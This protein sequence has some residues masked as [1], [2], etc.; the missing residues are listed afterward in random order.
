M[1][2]FKLELQLTLVALL[3]LLN[4]DSKILVLLPVDL[5]TLG[6]IV[7]KVATIAALVLVVVGL[8]DSLVGEVLVLS[9]LEDEAESG[10]V[11]I[12]HADIGEGLE[13]LLVAVGDHLGEG[14]LVLHGREPELGDTRNLLGRLGSLLLLGGGLGLLIVLLILLTGL[15]LVL[16]GLSL[17]VDNGS[18][19]LV[20]RSELGEVL[21]LELKDLLL[22]LGLKLG[23]LLLD[24][25]QASDT[26]LDIG[27]ERLNVAG[28]TTDKR[29]ETALDK[30]HKSGVLGED[31]SGGGTVKVLLQRTVSL[32][33]S[34]ENYQSLGSSKNLHSPSL[35]LATPGC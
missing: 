17:A 4:A 5:V 10:L 23:V 12:L 11:E 19:L 30:G 8:G 2:K 24:A 6:V 28:R 1:R 34:P 35:M 7:D 31:G 29:A 33:K 14:D 3:L 26:T 27:R 32:A 13:G 9:E 21:L 20:K 22:E 25:L 18:T 16:S 15:D